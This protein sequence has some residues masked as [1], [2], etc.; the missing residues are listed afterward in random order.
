MHAARQAR[1]HTQ[2]T[3]IGA[4]FSPFSFLS[5]LPTL[6]VDFCASAK[7]AFACAFACLLLGFPSPGKCCL[8][9]A[10]SKLRCSCFFCLA[11]R[12]FF[13]LSFAA[14]GSTDPS[15]PGP[16]SKIAVWSSPARL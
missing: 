15:S 2:R 12:S 1:V 13:S 8:P 11:T 7:A 16:A 4:R 10:S 9:A 14:N 3:L 5:N 6:A